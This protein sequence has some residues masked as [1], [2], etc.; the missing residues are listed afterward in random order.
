MRWVTALHHLA[1]LDHRRRLLEPVTS[2]SGS[3]SPRPGRRSARPR[4]LRRPSRARAPE[5]RCGSPPGSPPS[6]S[7][8]I[9]HPAELA[10][11][12]CRAASR[13]RRWRTPCLTPARWAA[14]K[15]SRWI[16]A[17]S[18]SFLRLSS[19]TPFFAPSAWVY[20]VLKMSIAKPRLPRSPG[21]ADALGVDQAGMLDRVDPGADR[22]LDPGGAMGVGGDP[23]APLVRLVGD[24]AQLLLGQLLLAGLGVAREDPAGGADLDHLGAV[25]ALLADPVRSSSGRRRPPCRRACEGRAA[26]RSGRNGR[27]SRPARRRRGRSAA[28]P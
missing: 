27:R 8:H 11:R 19:S 26:D 16:W 5:R 13:R 12:R 23:Q 2:A 21:E 9:D 7:F 22:G 15:L 10:G 14:R 1:A 3:P 4:S 18:R 24:R 20:S 28:R 6:G 25:F 17:I